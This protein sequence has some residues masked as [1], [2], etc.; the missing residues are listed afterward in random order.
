M[1]ALRQLYWIPSAR[2]VTRRLLQHCVVCK[3]VNG[4]P[5]QVPDPPPLIKER[6]QSAQP[7]EF[8]G[9][10][11]TGAL[12]VREQGGESKVY[13]C[14]FTCA[15]SRAVHLEIVTDLTVETFL[16]AFRRF[17]SHKS[18]P[19]LM[20]SDNA[21]TYMSAAEELQ[22]LFNSTL[23]TESLHRKGV[24]WK[25]IPKCAPWYGG[26]WE[27]LIGLTKTALKKVLG[28]TFAT[29]SSLQ[30]LIVEVEAMLNDR[31]LTYVSPD[32]AD[33]EPLT[34]AHLLYGRR[35]T[36]LPHPM[37]E[38][39]ELTDPNYGTESELRKRANTQALILK[40][41]W[42]RWKLEYL[43][44][45]REFHKTTGNNVQKVQV[46]DVVLVHD[47]IPRIRWE[48]AVIEDVI[49]GSDGLIRAANIR[50]KG[51]RTNRP[52]SKL[53]PL[54]VTS[55]ECADRP[56]SPLPTSNNTGEEQS[57]F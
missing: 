7:F 47:D 51:G 32:V 2:Q 26:F 44:S 1:T 8:T 35:I 37:V 24:M 20:I 46:G 21:S 38:D 55:I 22:Q 31:P 30:T 40:H 28:Q 9:V 19:R 3:R 42:K 10:D 13:V 11:F 4:K 57:E 34:P 6:I 29:L 15:V 53:Y 27:R 48:L 16:Q 23:L 39:D 49:K 56:E 17:S 45:L 41:F 12:Y 50:T 52:I 36:S 33:P 5:Y 25:F 14:L 18:L 43:T 54:E